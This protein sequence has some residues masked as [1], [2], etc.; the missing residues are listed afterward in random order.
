MA[1]RRLGNDPKHRGGV[2]ELT[3]PCTT[4][5]RPG[6]KLG[7]PMRRRHFVCACAGFGLALKGT[8]AHSFSLDKDDNPPS[9]TRVQPPV[10][11]APTPS[12]GQGSGN[13]SSSG[14]AGGL[15]YVGGCSLIGTAS[16]AP[17]R[18][19]RVVRRSGVP[20]IDGMLA[21]ESARLV[22]L[23]EVN[24]DVAWFDDSGA[25]NALATPQQLIG[26]SPHGTVLMGLQLTREMLQRFGNM[27]VMAT[28]IPM[29]VLA[30]EYAHILQFDFLSR[31]ARLRHQGHPPEL[32]ADFLAGV[33]MGQ[34][35]LE[36]ARF[37]ATDLRPQ[38]VGA[39][40]QFY[41]IGNLDFNNPG[42][43][44]TKP[45]RLAAFRGG[46]ALVEET[47]ARGGYMRSG[48]IF[49]VARDRIGY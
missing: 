12:T 46:I 5:L 14:S 1:E 34:R 16:A 3:V 13:G 22:A 27:G 26:S 41:S 4:Y 44:G 23:Y 31:G 24:P 40:Q 8:A 30:H 47:L 10:Q 36:A 33:Y 35:A 38:L 2:C 15:S 48:E 19:L 29:A 17:L 39:M 20:L 28:W 32:H 6:L 21:Q 11:Q 49:E 42:T 7:I 37:H 43:H 45:Q 9:S 18:R 25:P